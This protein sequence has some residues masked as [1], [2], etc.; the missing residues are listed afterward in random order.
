MYDP[1]D[2]VLYG[3][4]RAIVREKREAGAMKLV[5]YRLT[6][7]RVQALFE[8]AADAELFDD[9]DYSLDAQVSDGGSLVIM[10]RTEEREHVIKIHLPS[11]DDSGARGEAAEFAQSLE[12][13]RWAAGDFSGR[14]AP[15]RPDRVAV[16]YQVSADMATT[17][18]NGAPRRWALPEP[19]PIRPHCVVLTG[20]T[21]T[22]AQEIGESNPLTTRWQHDGVTF[23]AWIRPLLP[24]EEDCRATELRYLE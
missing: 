24:D 13:S 3:N 15:Y 11:P 10:L 2:F 22:R 5:E 17:S 23:Q 18:G 20:A 16:S 12:P 4:G 6:A 21:A 9:E 7:E 8:E 1:P 14:P 19:E